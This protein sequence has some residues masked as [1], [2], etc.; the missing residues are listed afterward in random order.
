[1]DRCGQEQAPCGLAVAVSLAGRGGRAS[2]HGS[3]DRLVSKGSASLQRSIPRRHLL[4]Q[5]WS[6][7]S[8][9]LLDKTSSLMTPSDA[10]L[11]FKRLRASTWRE[12]RIPDIMSGMSA[13]GH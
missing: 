7:N 8:A 1:M 6:P 4:D 12:I 5:T 2:R 9:P 3:P 13:L 11:R 10:K